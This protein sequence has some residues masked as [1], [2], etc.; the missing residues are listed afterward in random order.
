MKKKFVK[1]V[2]PP[3]TGKREYTY[4]VDFPIAVKDYA[5]VYTPTN[6]YQVVQ[7]RSVRIDTVCDFE[8]R[9]LIQKVEV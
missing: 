5:V 9:A 1:A 7:I 8:V 6:G 3:Y 2:F 4:S